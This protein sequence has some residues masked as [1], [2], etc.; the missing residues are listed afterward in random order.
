MLGM[1]IRGESMIDTTWKEDDYNEIEIS[2]VQRIRRNT[3]GLR[4]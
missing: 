1:E 4:P 3:S 2:K